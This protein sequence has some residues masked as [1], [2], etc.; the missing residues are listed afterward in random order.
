MSQLVTELDKQRASLK[1]DISALIQESVATL[2]SS[3][4]VLTEIVNS[5][6]TQLNA[7]ECLAEDNLHY[8][9][10]KKRLKR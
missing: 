6:Q 8:I 7:T 9:Q 5:F 3:V 1:E 10:W 2:Q 4:N